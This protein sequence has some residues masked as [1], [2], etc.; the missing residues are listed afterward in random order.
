[1]N[2]LCTS[3]YKIL[4]LT[5]HIKNYIRK[6]RSYNKDFLMVVGTIGRGRH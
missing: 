6:N 3:G 4:I 1:M 2:Y 5:N